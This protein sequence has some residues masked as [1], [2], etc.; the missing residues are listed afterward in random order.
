MRSRIS[1][2]SAQVVMKSASGGASGS[3]QRR[4]PASAIGP[5]PAERIDGEIDRLRSGLAGGDAAL[6]GRTENQNVAAEFG[7]AAGQRRQI[8]GGGLAHGGV[9][10]SELQSLG[11][12]EE[13][14]Q[15]EQGQSAI[16][17][18][19]PQL[20]APLRR[21]VG[22]AAGKGERRHLQA[23]IA[24]PA[25]EAQTRRWSQPSNVSL[26]IA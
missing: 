23:A 4:T 26:Q 1:T 19:P 10:R 17:G 25:D 3:R 6:G 22:D 9:G 14:V 8:V 20:A 7:A 12:G 21:H 24:Q 11:A 15:A 18:L 5:G 16:L 13:P 2:A